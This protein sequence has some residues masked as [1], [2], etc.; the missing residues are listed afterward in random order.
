M[1]YYIREAKRD[2]FCYQ[3]GI[4]KKSPADIL[5]ELKERLIESCGGW[6]YADDAKDV[7][8]LKNV[9]LGD[10]T[11]PLRGLLVSYQIKVGS[12][13]FVFE[14]PK[15]QY[16][17]MWDLPSLGELVDYAAYRVQWPKD[18]LSCLECATLH[19]IDSRGCAVHRDGP[20][21]LQYGKNLMTL[22]T[23]TQWYNKVLDLVVRNYWESS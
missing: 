18:R 21:P 1:D 12:E 8:Y 16:D 15:T 5:R 3:L 14:V 6:E 19:D 4:S 11:G 20:R 23:E 13:W 9:Y 7:R 10:H 22:L 17:D 2:L